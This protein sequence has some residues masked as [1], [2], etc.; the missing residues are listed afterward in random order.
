MG[1]GPSHHLPVAAKAP[2]GL[3]SGIRPMA[4][5]PI[6][7]AGASSESLPNVPT[8]RLAARP[9]PASKLP[10]QP[11]V[12]LTATPLPKVGPKGTQKLTD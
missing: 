11:T 10:T 2:P 1:W 9:M 8:T 3:G 12:K 5:P 4:T 6:A 7:P